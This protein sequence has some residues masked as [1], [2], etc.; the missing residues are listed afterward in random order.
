MADLIDREAAKE[1]VKY[2]P[3]CDWKAVGDCLDKLPA[4]EVVHGWWIFGHTIG[5]AWMKCS[6]CLK[7]Q[8]PNG[9]F[10]YCPNC[11]AKMDGE[12]REENAA[13]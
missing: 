5:R 8:M 10:T 2:I 1:A 6:E 9:C 11:G 3:W 13:D 7:S 12:R 4:V